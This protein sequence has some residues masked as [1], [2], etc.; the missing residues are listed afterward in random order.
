EVTDAPARRR[1][2]AEEDVT[3]RPRGGRSWRDEGE[4]PPV[5]KPARK[6][7]GGLGILVLMLTLLMLIGYGA[8]LVLVLIGAIDV[9][10]PGGDDEATYKRKRDE[11]R[12]R[13]RPDGDKDRTEKDKPGK[14]GVKDKDK[15]KDKP[16]KDRPDK[17]KDLSK[18]DL[19]DLPPRDEAAERKL[20]D[21]R[22]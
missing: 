5:R 11:A 8:G 20:A 16:D 21:E 17:D 6:K 9:K 18:G 1:R 2:A 14:D 3:E 7:K 19:P 10:L 4:E 13:I 12:N 22:G 15:P